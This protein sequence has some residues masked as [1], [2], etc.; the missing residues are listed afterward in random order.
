MNQRSE[1]F[2]S[3]ADRERDDAMCARF[4]TVNL[5]AIQADAALKQIR[6]DNV[7][8]MRI[9]GPFGTYNFVL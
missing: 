2:R 9:P 7:D 8:R 3:K 6:R 1:Q 4:A 5:P